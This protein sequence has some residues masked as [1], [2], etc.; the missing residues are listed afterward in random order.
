MCT[1]SCKREKRRGEETTTS[2]KP[3]IIRRRMPYSEEKDTMMFSNTPWNDRLGH[4]MISHEPPKWR[5]CYPL[6][7]A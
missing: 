7:D 4:W 5:R 2:N 3:S 6:A 1:F